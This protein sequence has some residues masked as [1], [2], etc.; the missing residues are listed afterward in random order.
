LPVGRLPVIAGFIRAA[1]AAALA[2]RKE[3]VAAGR[4]V[5]RT[6]SLPNA[7]RRRADVVYDCQSRCC[8]VRRIAALLPV[9]P[10]KRIEP[11]RP[12]G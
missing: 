4:S 2:A 10:A 6:A 12:R 8:I 1:V 7:G 3:L 11:A 9:H 5:R